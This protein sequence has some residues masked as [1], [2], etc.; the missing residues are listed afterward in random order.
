M[1]TAGGAHG[2]E[3]IGSG[4][5]W[6]VTADQHQADVL[7]PGFDRR[8]QRALPRFAVDHER[9]HL[10]GKERAVGDGEDVQ[11]ARQHVGGTR[12]FAAL[13]FHSGGGFAYVFGFHF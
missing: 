6:I 8:F 11:Q 13:G 9:H 5:L 4:G 7:V 1:N 3:V 2:V 12:Q 10:C